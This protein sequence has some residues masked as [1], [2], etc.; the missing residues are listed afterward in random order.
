MND[1]K[2]LLGKSE[3]Y[4]NAEIK[5]ESEA[6]KYPLLWEVI[7]INDEVGKKFTIELLEK[8]N[9]LPKEK[10]I[11]KLDGEPTDKMRSA[12]CDFK[13]VDCFREVL[14]PLLDRFSILDERTNEPVPKFAILKEAQNAISERLITM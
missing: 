9:N 4:N 7:F 14:N 13:S 8:F 10:G 5:D 6:K 3:V 12:E 2:Y 11:V 1:K